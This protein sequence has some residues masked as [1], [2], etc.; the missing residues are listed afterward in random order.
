GSGV[1]DI[2]E[3]GSIPLDGGSPNSVDDEPIPSGSIQSVQPQTQM[4]GAE[5]PSEAMAT[6]SKE[7]R[8]GLQQN[9][10]S[11]G[12]VSGSKSGQSIASTFGR[13][14]STGF[15]LG[16]FAR[17]TA[18]SLATRGRAY[19]S[20]GKGKIR[21]VGRTAKMVGGGAVKSVS[22]STP[23]TYARGR[24]SSIGQTVRSVGAGAV[25]SV[26]QSP[27]VTYAR[28]TASNLGQTVKSVGASV[29][30]AVSQSPTVTYT[31]GA[32]SSV[33]QTIGSVGAGAV[34]SVAQSPTVT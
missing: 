21:S 16:S 31:K 6:G 23:M 13:G 15:A 20:F 11:E 18:S 2:D 26:A 25:Q 27:T 22:R 5:N 14:Y 12:I 28:G 4:Q 10:G 19:S 17:G 24:A 29:G 3:G 9:Q 33:G 1:S 32:V 30:Q 8:Q 34:Q 7:I